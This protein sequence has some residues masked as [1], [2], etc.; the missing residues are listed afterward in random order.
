MQVKVCAQGLKRWLTKFSS[1]N[2]LWKGHKSLTPAQKIW[3]PLLTCLGTATHPKYK[4]KIIQNET[5]GQDGAEEAAGTA[6]AKVHAGRAP[7][8]RGASSASDQD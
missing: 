6:D 8:C 3:H 7:P 2:P 1:Q 4:V 5:V